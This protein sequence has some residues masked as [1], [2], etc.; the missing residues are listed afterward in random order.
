[1]GSLALAAPLARADAGDL[2]PWRDAEDLPIPDGARSIVVLKDDQQ[3]LAEP[4][5][6]GARRGAARAHARLPIFGAK[7]GAGCAARWFNVGPFAWVCQ[8]GLEVSASAPLGFAG[9]GPGA[10]VA[11][12]GLPFRYYFVGPGGTNGYSRL[13][14]AED[15]APDQELEPGFA[16]AVVDEGTKQG[17]RYV[18]SH[19]GGWIPVRDLVPVVP[20]LFHGEE[21]RDG[22]LDFGW[23]I[24]ERVPVFA[25]ASPRMT[26]P[27][28][29]RARFEKVAILEE[30]REKNGGGYVR[31]AEGQWVRSRDVRRPSL[32]LPPSVLRTGER[33]IDVD[34]ATQTLVA[35]EGDRPIFATL[36]STGKGKEGTDSAT[37]KG[38]FRIWVKLETSNMD[39]LE[40]EEAERYY[41]IEDVP[42][43]Q[44]FSQGVGLHGAFWHRGFGRVR[45][46]GCVNL[47]PLDAQRLFAFTSPHLPLGWTAALPSPVEEGTLVRVR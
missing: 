31:I 35:A 1:M 34:L 13:A 4:L 45:S 44:Y 21:A 36:V 11:P 7:R 29:Y 12:A 5:A 32:S 15:V 22:K 3:I 8:D 2:P 27:P 17:E 33:W 24:D 9:N 30:K 25:A 40:D 18:R 10:L 43:V 28:V 20:F 14:D 46:H 23:I 47:A 41:A 26:K 6:T 37:P 42:Y 19:H 16:V 38:D 39:N